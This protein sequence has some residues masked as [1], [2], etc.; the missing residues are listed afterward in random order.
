MA[1]II[2]VDGPSGAGKTHVACGIGL[3][4]CQRGVKTRFA[5]A[6]A[7]HSKCR[8]MHNFAVLMP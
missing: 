3:A 5:T 6:A 7:M 4:A 2:A 1:I 8:P